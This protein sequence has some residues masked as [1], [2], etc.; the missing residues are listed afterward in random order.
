MGLGDRSGTLKPGARRE[1]GETSRSV[2]SGEHADAREGRGSGQWGAP[3]EGARLERP[4]I[5]GSTGA[6]TIGYSVGS[7]QTVPDE[8]DDTYVPYHINQGRTPQISGQ[9]KRIFRS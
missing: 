1:G 7:V 2:W 5:D 8:T 9:S 3:I 6:L 4:A